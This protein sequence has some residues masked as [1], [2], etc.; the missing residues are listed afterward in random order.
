MAKPFEGT[1]DLDIRN[2]E[3]DWEPFEPPKAPEGAPSVVYI[4]LDDVGFSAMSCYGGPIETPNIDRI[5]SEGT[6]YT[7]WHTTALCSP[8]RSCLLT[9]RNHTRNSMACITEAAVGFPNASGTIPPENGMLPEIL[10]ELGWNTYM[11]GKW[12]LCPTD[13]M[14][15]ASTRRN[16]PTGRGFER[17][18]G[19]L[20]AE[21]NQWYPDLVYD[22]HPVDPPR[23]PEEG[24]HFGEDITD[25]ALE[26]IKDA[27]AVAPD[28]P[29][30]LYYAPGAAHAPHHAPKEWIDKYRGRFDMGYEAIREQTLARQKEMGLV[31]QETELPPINPIGTPETRT[32]PGGAPF[33]ALEYTKPWSSLSADE[34]R[35]FS[36]MAEVYAG[37]LA[38]ADQ[39]IGRLLDHLEE[40]GLRENTMVVVVSDN[41]AS[42]EGGPDGSVNENLFFNG[43]PD[44]MATNLS[45]IDELGGTETYNHYPNG[46]AMAFNTP[47]KMWKRYEFNGGTSDPCIISY[48][49]GGGRGEV[50][51]Q[52]HH[53]IDVVPT[54][55]DVLG[56]AAPGTIK[57]NVQSRFDGVSM[58]YA[59]EDASAPAARR[60]QFYSMLGSRAIWH[61]GWKAVTTHPTISGWGHFNEDVWELYH[62]DVDRSELHD[63]AAEE[64]DKLRELVSLWFAEAGAN[65]AFPLDDRSA[66]EILLT[67]RPQLTLP[68]DRYVYFPDVADV[69]EH[70][71]VNVRNRSY[72]IGALVDIP[73][74]GAQGVLFAHGARFGGHALYVKDDRLH[75]VNNFAG[76]L[77][78]RVDGTE[79]VPTGEQLI[80]SAS[81]D[82]DG[83]DPPGVATGIL[84]LYHGDRKVG[85][86]RIKTQPG[87]FELAGEGLCVGRDSGSA[88]TDDEPGEAPHRFT[89]GTIHRVAVDVSGEPYLDLERQAEAMLARE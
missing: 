67:P 46:W 48:P 24:Y 1:I 47:F 21:T 69:P 80:L 28:K 5:A 18:Y 78:Q 12:H 8:T 36:R 4:V 17:F 61:D 83:E 74:P 63:L 70:Q 68:R 77:E 89:G 66:L 6:R 60:T 3:P 85:E 50:R 49:S 45:M 43:I 19:F 30:F 55:L 27:K 59:A 34:Q 9:G 79:D 26:F 23:S 15:L 42:G 53:A 82:K 56:V 25:K 31:P 22:N 76:M 38:H 88:V 57:G 29:F 65:G 71:A 7:Q 86:A 40:A 62:T 54:I 58:R 81:F 51:H 75:Y 64:P 73:A 72:T 41:G 33:P 87:F 14:N 32:G 16:W 11:V 37:F 20:G 84:S 10:G 39:Q 52:Y 35:L 13:E 44:D 2:S